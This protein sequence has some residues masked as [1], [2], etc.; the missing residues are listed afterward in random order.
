MA[1]EEEWRKKNYEEW[2]GR[3]GNNSMG[4]QANQAGYQRYLDEQKRS[5]GSG[6]NSN[7]GCF[8]AGTSIL[9]PSGICDISSLSQGDIVLGVNVKDG[10]LQPK[11][12]LKTIRH[13][14]N[15]IWELALQ[16][17]NKVK[18]TSI[19]SFESGG[20]WL[21]ASTIRP[22][23]VVLT[24]NKLGELE[25]Q[26]VVGSGQLSATEDVY[27]L[28]VKDHFTFV[29]DGFV[30]HCFSHFR[31]MRMH[32]WSVASVLLSRSPLSAGSTILAR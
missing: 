32:I 10:Q 2:V 11:P 19:H 1:T 12:I 5:D 24:A 26:R 8:P 25:E 30:A 6:G 16:N 23:D 14:D 13:R 9:T 22:G 4:T 7:N 20:K 28:I 18:T 27:N 31:Y 3:Q 29:A 21:K 17:G 15:R